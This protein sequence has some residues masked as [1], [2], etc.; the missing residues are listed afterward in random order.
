MVKGSVKI[1]GLLSNVSSQRIQYKPYS[2]TLSFSGDGGSTKVLV[3]LSISKERIVEQGDDFVVVDL[4]GLNVILE[5][6][7]DSIDRLDQN[8][9]RKLGV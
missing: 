2:N 9:K 1:R 6:T 5:V 8:Y 4:D 3:E 7:A